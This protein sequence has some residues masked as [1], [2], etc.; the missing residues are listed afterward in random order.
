MKRPALI[1][2]FPDRLEDLPRSCLSSCT[3]RLA[4]CRRN[5]AQSPVGN[6][7][8]GFFSALGASKVR[9]LKS[10]PALIVS[11]ALKWWSLISPKL[12][13]RSTVSAKNSR[14]TSSQSSAPA[15][16]KVV[17]ESNRKSQSCLGTWACSTLPTPGKT[18]LNC[19]EQTLKGKDA[20]YAL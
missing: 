20:S 11:S 16:F 1:R 3:S 5:R 17:S 4:R 13:A 19:N 12:C 2:Y 7:D 14:A 6:M 9:A 8:Y 18:D 10:P 15:C